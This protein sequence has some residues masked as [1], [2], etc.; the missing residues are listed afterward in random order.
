[1]WSVLCACL[2]TNNTSY[3]TARFLPSTLL[4]KCLHHLTPKWMHYIVIKRYING[5]RVI[6]LQ[7]QTFS[8]KRAWTFAIQKICNIRAIK[9]PVARMWSMWSYI[10][11]G[12]RPNS[13]AIR[14]YLFQF[15][16]LQGHLWYLNN[17]IEMKWLWLVS[18]TLGPVSSSPFTLV[19]NKSYLYAE[20]DNYISLW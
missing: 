15:L 3:I 10:F 2:D 18:H 7:W 20:A 1:M 11:Q 16:Q 17:Y 5:K 8:E 14:R 13:M 4:E 19:V 9:S 6:T 12:F